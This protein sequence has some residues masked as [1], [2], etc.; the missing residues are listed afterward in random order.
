MAKTTTR[1]RR[2]R[3]TGRFTLDEALIALFIGAMNANDHVAPDEAARAQHLIWSTRRF[4]RKSGDA[5]GKLTQEMRRLIEDSD[6]K[7]VITRAARAVPAKLRPSAFALVADLLLADGE[8]EGRE[9]RF[10]VGLGGELK[11]DQAAARRIIDV[12]V[13]KNQL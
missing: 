2:G 13:L 8:L 3:R 5:V 9:R 4:R 7:A 10:L 12:I 1:T 6:A 11:L